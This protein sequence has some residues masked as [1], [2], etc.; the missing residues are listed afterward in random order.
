MKLGKRVYRNKLN[1]EL[2]REMIGFKPH[3]LTFNT[4]T[5]KLF[6]DGARFF[7]NVENQSDMR[8]ATDEDI[9]TYMEEVNN[10]ATGA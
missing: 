10:S 6:K 8:L 3:N 1:G 4:E 9:A 5:T 2:Y 7:L